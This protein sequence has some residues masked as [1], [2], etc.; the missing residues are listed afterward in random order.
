MTFIYNMFQHVFMASNYGQMPV[1]G[2]NF[3]VTQLTIQ[4]WKFFIHFTISRFWALAGIWVIF[5]LHRGLTLTQVAIVDGVFFGSMFLFEIPTGIVADKFGRKQSLVIS[6]FTQ[7]VGILLFAYSNNLVMF[8]VAFLIWGIG[9]TLNSGAEEAWLYDEVKYH[10][11]ITGN[12]IEN[13]YQRVYGLLLSVGLISTSLA[14][15]VGGYLASYSLHLPIVLTS[16]M[17]LVS[18]LWVSRIPENKIKTTKKEEVTPVEESSLKDAVNNFRS[19]TLIV[20]TI[21]SMLMGGIISSF[22]YWMQPYLVGNSVSLTGIGFF[23][24]IGVLIASFGSSLSGALTK[25]FKDNALVSFTLATSIAFVLMSLL[26]HLGVI[27][28][29]LII[30]FLRGAFNPYLSKLVNEIIPS[31]TRATTLSIISALT[32]FSIMIMGLISAMMVEMV[33]FDLFYIFSGII[34]L[35]LVP[36]LIFSKKR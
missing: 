26:S 35:I 33:S 14:Y 32:T 31:D 21:T 36:L 25:R 28:L 27:A 8:C 24:G 6:Y 16:V 22:F 3:I 30:R 12:I 13:R 4:E 34:L 19:P 15:V 10:G 2:H 7:F 5:L 29:F 17:F 1:K 11:E 23:L 9:M 18:S 20:L